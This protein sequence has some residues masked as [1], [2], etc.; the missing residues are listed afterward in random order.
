MEKTLDDKDFKILEIIQNHPTIHHRKLMAI[1]EDKGILS[2]TPAAKRIKRMLDN[3]ILAF[4]YGKEK[5]Y[6]LS[7][8]QLSEENL[9]Q[10]TS[11][12][13]K[14]LRKEL[15]ILD[16]EFLNYDWEIKSNL[17]D[18]LTQMVSNFLEKKSNMQRL[19]R[20]TKLI[21]MSDAEEIFSD[22]RQLTED[23]P[24]D[25]PKQDKRTLAGK[26]MTSISKK[27]C[28]YAKL[29]ESRRKMGASKKRELTSEKLKQINSEITDS[30]NLLENIRGELKS[31][32]R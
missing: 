27:Q 19:A 12:L 3:K 7:D 24:Y 16:K 9:Y 8:N 13:I 6:V 25:N 10:K 20:E 29:S 11:K 32:K 30:Y 22:I 26:T 28:E 1:I 4:H 23:L 18:Y 17:P 15:E 21:D 5:Q 14:I 31:M 2:K